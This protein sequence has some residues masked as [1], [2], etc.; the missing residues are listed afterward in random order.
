[1][2]VF[3]HDH[4]PVDYESIFTASLFENPQ[5]KI[6]PPWGEMRLSAIT[7]AGNEMQIIAAI[8]RCKP[9]VT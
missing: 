1:M 5:E 4:I 7:T 3:G 8:E 6:M 9:L 2:K